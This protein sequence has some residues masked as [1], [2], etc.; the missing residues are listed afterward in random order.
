MHTS[1]C[2]VKSDKTNVCCKCLCVLFGNPIKSSRALTS[3]NLM[4]WKNIIHEHT[5]TDIKDIKYLQGPGM[6]GWI[7]I[8]Y[9]PD[10]SWLERPDSLWPSVHGFIIARFNPLA[11]LCRLCCSL[12]TTDRSH[13]TYISLEKSF[14]ILLFLYK[15][16]LHLVV[17][18]RFFCLFHLYFPWSRKIKMWRVYMR[19]VWLYKSTSK[20]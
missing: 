8:C 3:E 4:S 18:L 1:I 20:I 6:N 15:I 16:T 12:A 13:Y 10:S 7:S 17:T 2:W 19:S 14:L 5:D 11:L 9:R